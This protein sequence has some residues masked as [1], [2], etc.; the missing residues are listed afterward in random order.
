MAESAIRAFFG[1]NA[2]VAI[3][4]LT[5]ITISSFA[6]ASVF[7]RKIWRICGCIGRRAS[8]T[9]TSFGGKPKS[10][11]LCPSTRRYPAATNASG[12]RP[13]GTRKIDEFANRF[14]DT[15]EQLNGLLSDA[16]DQAQVLRETMLQLGS[17]A[18]LP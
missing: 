12:S 15:G 13:G 7:S 3:I 11:P 16:T 10:R 8:N 2:L 17:H 5:L 6:R 9:W 4:V 18:V 1:S 14:S